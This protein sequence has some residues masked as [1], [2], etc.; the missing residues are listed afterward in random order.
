MSAILSISILR[1]KIPNSRYAQISKIAGTKHNKIADLPFFFRSARFKFRPALVKIIIKASCLKSGDIAIILGEIK[2]SRCGL[3]VI[4]IS[5]IP[6]SDGRCNLLHI[7]P[8]INALN[9]IIANDVRKFI[10]ANPPKK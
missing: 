1:I 6:K 4:P 5:N 9:T 8:S 3:N 10:I 2:F 7:E